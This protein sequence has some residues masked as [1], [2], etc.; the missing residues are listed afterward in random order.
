MEKIRIKFTIRDYY[1]YIGTNPYYS[2]YYS[3]KERMLNSIPKE[4]K[5][6]GYNIKFKKIENRLYSWMAFYRIHMSLKMQEEQ[7]KNILER[8]KDMY[9]FLDNISY[10]V[11]INKFN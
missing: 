5:K 7:L 4:F 11:I 10:K 6:V 1:D 8:Y 3:T 2:T 9:L